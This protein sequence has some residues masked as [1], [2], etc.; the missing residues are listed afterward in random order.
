[1]IIEILLKQDCLLKVYIGPVIN[2]LNPAEAWYTHK[3][4]K[5]GTYSSIKSGIIKRAIIS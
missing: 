2:R 3:Y 5:M 4:S 1:M